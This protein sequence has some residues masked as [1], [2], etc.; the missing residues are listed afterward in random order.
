M[1]WEPQRLHH[2]SIGNTLTINMHGVTCHYEYRT[3]Q[4]ISQ[5]PTGRLPLQYNSDLIHI[6]QAP[7]S[8]PNNP[9]FQHT[10]PTH[11]PHDFCCFDLPPRHSSGVQFLCF[12]KAQRTQSLYSQSDHRPVLPSRHDTKKRTYGERWVQIENWS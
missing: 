11:S 10:L 6:N 2:C 1:L 9:Q 4:M 5:T 7:V 12:V 8:I 3:Q